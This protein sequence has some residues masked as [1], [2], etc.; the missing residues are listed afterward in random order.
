VEVECDEVPHDP[1]LDE[2]HSGQTV[3]ATDRNAITVTTTATAMSA[4]IT[5]FWMNLASQSQ[6]VFF[7][8]FFQKKIL[9]NKWHGFSTGRKTLPIT[10]KPIMSDHLRKLKSTDSNQKNLST[11]IILSSSATGI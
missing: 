4:L 7:F 5:S 2:E 3:D 1:R 8:H 10:K 11:G 9:G 6:S